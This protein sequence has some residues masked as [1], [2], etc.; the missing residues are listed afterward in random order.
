M[1]RYKLVLEYDGG[2][3]QG[4][5]RQSEGPSVQASLEAA[6]LAF[7]GEAVQV[8]AAG[9]T[10]AGVHARGQVAHLDLAR[11]VALDTLRNALNHHLRPQPVVV[12]DAAPVGEDFHARFDARM[13]HYRYRIVNRRAPLALDRGRAWLVPRRLDAEMM[14]EAGQ[15]LVGRHDFASFRSALCQAKSPVKTLS[16]LTV[17][18]CGSEIE[19]WARARSFLHHQ[20]RNMVGTLKLVGEGRWSV[21]RID[22]VLAARDRAAA[23][24]TAPACGLCLM[25]VDYCG[26]TSAGRRWR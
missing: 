24:P 4:W 11:E 9:R 3:F 26:A 13:R 17:V 16:H 22:A 6:V 21:D 5:Q 19:L 23:G 1:P 25:Q 8:T 20:V 10:D 12:L 14:H 7:C 15:R 2:P 18:R